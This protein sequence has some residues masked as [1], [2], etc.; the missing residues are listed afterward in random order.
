MLRVKVISILVQAIL[1][2]EVVFMLLDALS[3]VFC[4]CGI[5]VLQ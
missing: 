4:Y 2:D 5:L 1:Q 3:P